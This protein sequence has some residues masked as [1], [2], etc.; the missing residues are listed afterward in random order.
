MHVLTSTGYHVE[1]RM[2]LIVIGNSMTV[3]KFF[4]HSLLDIC[5]IQPSVVYQVSCS[6][7]TYLR[8]SSL[9]P[10]QMVAR[11]AS[12]QVCMYIL[13]TN[14]VKWRSFI[15]KDSFVTYP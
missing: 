15:D 5:I 3:H 14:E 6:W 2:D 7:S 1:S 9:E 12:H 8:I 10:K 11:A 4:S 13:L